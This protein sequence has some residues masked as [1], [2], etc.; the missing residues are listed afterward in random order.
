P[1]GVRRRAAGCGPVV[2]RSGGGVVVGDVPFEP[3]PAKDGEKPAADAT[4][5]V[6]IVWIDGAGAA[7]VDGRKV[8]AVTCD[9]APDTVRVLGVDAAVRGAERLAKAR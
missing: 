4:R 2:L 9:V 3:V 5:V 7:L 1:R 8:A 6:E